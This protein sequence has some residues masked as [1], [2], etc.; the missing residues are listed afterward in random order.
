MA[1]CWSGNWYSLPSGAVVN[2]VPM[3]SFRSS[4]GLVYSLPAPDM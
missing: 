2:L 3:K 4:P 1:N